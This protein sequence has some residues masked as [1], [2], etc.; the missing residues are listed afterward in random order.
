MKIKVPQRN[1]ALQSQPQTIVVEQKPGLFMHTLNLG[2]GCFCVVAIVAI[3]LVVVAL[4]KAS[5]ADEGFRRNRAQAIEQ[6]RA[7]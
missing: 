2:C 7:N 6:S 5:N 4:V 1:S 3:I